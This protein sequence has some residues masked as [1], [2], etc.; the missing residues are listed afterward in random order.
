MKKLKENRMSY[1]IKNLL[2]PLPVI[3]SA[4][5]GIRVDFG[6]K[7]SGISDLRFP[8]NIEKVNKNATVFLCRTKMVGL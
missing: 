2:I 3:F 7:V 4:I 6:W 1:V 5:F 8:D